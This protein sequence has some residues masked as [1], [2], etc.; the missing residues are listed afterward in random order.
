MSAEMIKVPDD[1][2]TTQ[3][4]INAANPG[5][6]VSVASG[7]YY[8]KVVIDKSVTLKG[9]GNDITIIDGGGTRT[10]VTI[11]ADNVNVSGFTIRNS[12][13]GIHLRRSNNSTI[14]DNTITSNNWE[15]VY[16][17]YSNDNKVTG[18]TLTLDDRGIYLESSSGNTISD[19][20][21]SN[22]EYGL[23]I[24][25]SSINSFSGNTL[26]NNIYGIGVFF[27]RAVYRLSKYA[28]N[29]YF[30]VL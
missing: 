6:T 11:T 29:I 15:G 13:N 7:T 23:Y 16:L 3:E 25:S 14:S 21:V 20:V 18:N 17:Y 5:D 9:A 26:S 27:A 22:T 24:Y 4:A 1:Y 12:G 10:G 2:T 30:K 19:N 8:E 28:H